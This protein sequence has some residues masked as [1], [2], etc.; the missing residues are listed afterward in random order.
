MLL[1]KYGMMQCNGKNIR[2]VVMNNLLP[3]SIHLHAKYDL[4]GST[5]KRCASGRE[6]SKLSPTYK[7]LDFVE[8]NVDGLLLD[9]ETH[10]ALRKTIERDC[11]VCFVYL[12]GIIDCSCTGWAKKPDCFLKV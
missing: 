3:S 8:Q 4:K 1:T 10:D 5:H 7:D 2:F 6:R 9:A 11:R 12:Y